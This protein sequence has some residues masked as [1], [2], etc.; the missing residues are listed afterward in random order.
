[1]NTIG[2]VNS[3]KENEYR[4][5]LIPSDAK[6]I[7][8]K[9]AVFVENGYG[10]KNNYT[11]D[12][13]REAGVNVTSKEEVFKSDII[14]DPKI[15][16]AD[17]LK[18]IKNKIIFGWIHAVQNK[19]IT[20]ILIKNG[21]TAYAWEEM[22]EKG[23]HV[24]WRNNEV[25]GEVAIMHAIMLHGIMPY[26]TKVAIIGNGNTARGAYRVLIQLGANVKMYNRR[27]EQLLIDE[28]SQFDIVVNAV[29]WDINRQDHLITRQDLKKM[30]KGALII[31]I[32]CDKNGAIETSIPTSIDKPVYKVDGITHYVVDHTPS[33]VYKTVSKELSNAVIKYIDEL[34]TG[35]IS[36]VLKKANIIENGKI[37]DNKIIE[38]QNRKENIMEE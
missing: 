11:D 8:N 30:K 7:K 33:L 31:D 16:D 35:N 27:M 1:M 20:D 21:L 18:N 36:N 29:L 22:F 6:K 32:S 3:D 2:F 9:K 10:L 12:E 26:D 37:L 5:A 13:Y 24:F 38:F 25:A 14:V 4:I 19:D 17:Y 28:I 15:G 23:R 34:I